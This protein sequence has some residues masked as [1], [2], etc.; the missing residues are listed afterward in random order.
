[1]KF[2]IMT[3]AA[4]A[5][6]VAALTPAQW[7]G[8]SIYQVLTDRFARTD[9]STTAPCNTADGIYC[10]GTFQ[11]II[12]KLDYIQNMGF[13]AIWISPIVTNL[14]GDSGDGEAYHGY[15]AQ[16]IYS[17]NSNFGSSADL[18]AL[19]AALHARGM[20]LMVDV[21][22]NHMGYLGC[23][24]CVDYSVFNPFNSESYFHPFC[25]IDYTNA[26]SIKV[27]WEGD[28]TVSLPDMRTEDTDVLDVWESWITELVANYS[29]DG[30]RVDSAQQVDNA[31]FPPF[32]AAAGGIHILGEVF[33]GDP[34]YVCPYQSYMSGMLNYPAYFWITQAFESTTGSIS[35]LVN[36]IN[37]MKSTCSDTTLLGSF[38]ENHDNARFPSLTSDMS[39]TKNAIAFTVLA[40]GI[41]IIYEGQEQH[42]SG[43]GAN[44]ANREAIWLS[45]YNTSSPLYT[46]I[47]ALNKLR[48]HAL[49]LDT[50]YTTYKAY[51]IY[52]DTTTISM[53]KG[54]IVSVFSNL[55]AAGSSY[56][57]TLTAAETGFTANEEL[58]EVLGCTVVAVDASGGL[59]VRATSS[60]STSSTS[61]PVSSTTS[62]ASVS[63]TS[64]ATTTS[65]SSSCAIATA[66]PVTF[67]IL[68]TTTYGETIKLSGSIAALGSWNT[69]QAIS[70][71]AT[72]YTAANPLW[73]ATVSLPPGTAFQYKFI[74]VA[75]DGAVTWEA[76]PNR[77]FTVPTCATAAGVSVSGS[78]QS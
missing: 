3:L 8:Q 39:L 10:G 38:L 31:F 62:S 22:T 28:N 56:T 35:N 63:T 1:M 49:T 19:S 36:G 2:S 13:T 4:L 25:L 48:T 50:T 59:G 33:N 27:C 73:S 60:T 16:D 78:W 30:L 12:S 64:A 52:S 75:S 17:I 58:V 47:T 15:W 76:D 53:R 44:N 40:D 11:G 55:G 69:A 43:G 41:P 32:Q 42:Y 67:N 51:P 37:T 61:P 74:N 66:I 72:Q 9:D 6:T 46:F 65:T 68:A 26:T 23:G 71:S 77:S 5:T 14:V 57:L 54:S 70:L 45:G 18:I 20:Y 21:V 24:T 29:I 7:R 34:S